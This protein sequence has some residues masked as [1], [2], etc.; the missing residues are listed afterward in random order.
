MTAANRP[1]AETDVVP[2]KSGLRVMMTEAQVLAVVPISRSTL[3]RLERSGKFPKS[4]YIS[5]NRRCWFRDQIV[6]WQN[7]VDEFN[8]NRGRGNGRR[9][10][11]SSTSY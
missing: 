10:S 7:M 2:D 3:W 6:G 9:R 4:V 5:A 11:T 8:P 1:E